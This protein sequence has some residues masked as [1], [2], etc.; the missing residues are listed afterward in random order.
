MVMKILLTMKNNHNSRSSIFSRM[1]NLRTQ[2]S[3][4]MM[5]HN[6]CQMMMNVNLSLRVQHHHRRHEQHVT[7]SNTEHVQDCVKGRPF[8]C[9][10]V[11]NWTRKLPFPLLHYH[12]ILF[13]INLD[14]THWVL[15][16]I[17]STFEESKT[18]HHLGFKDS[19][20]GEKGPKHNAF[21]QKHCECEHEHKKHLYKPKCQV[22]KEF[23]IDNPE[24]PH[25][26]D[27]CDCGVWVCVF[28]F[29]E[30]R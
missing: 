19:L 7:P 20:W 8:T 23:I 2:S 28:C 3:Q 5:G 17:R 4:S 6:H 27:G 9:E 14:G 24:V 21:T 25:Q 12:L 30:A 18:T 29:C 10:H 13:P 26:G 15:E 11:E 16:R 1:G 22:R